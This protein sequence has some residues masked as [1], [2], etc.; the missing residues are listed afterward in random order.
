[1]DRRLIG[2]RFCENLGSLPGFGQGY[3][4]LLPSKAA[5]TGTAES[6]DQTSVIWTNGLIGSCLRHPFGIPSGPQA[7][8]SCSV[9][10]PSDVAGTYFFG[11]I[12]VCSLEH[13]FSSSFHPPF[14]GFVRQVMGYELVDSIRR[15]L[16]SQMPGLNLG[17]VKVKFPLCLTNH[18]A[19]KTIGGVEV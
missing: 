8:F 4:T 7:F 1:V 19:M 15:G 2:R 3:L 17:K 6:D 18:H 5:E 14:L 13:S 10:Q 11:R 12:V 9:F 16:S